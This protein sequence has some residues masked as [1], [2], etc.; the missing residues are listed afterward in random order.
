MVS[1]EGADLYTERRGG[2]PALL[3]IPGG[4]GDAGPFAPLADVLADT[5]TVLTYD[6]RGNS[7]SPLHGPPAPTTLAEQSADA[8]AVVRAHGFNEACFFGTSGGAII[9]LDLAAHHPGCM[10]LGVAHEPPVPK[11]LPDGQEILARYDEIDRVL[12]TEGWLKA[13]RMFTTGNPMSERDQPITQYVDPTEVDPIAALPPGPMRDTMVRMNG[14]WEF[15]TTYEIKSF[16]H[17][18]PDLDLIARNRVRLV[19]GGGS[20]TRSLFYHRSGRVIAERLGA[21]FVEFPGG[22]IGPFDKA[23]GF[24]QIIR[25]IWLTARQDESPR[26][27]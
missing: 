4:G 8:V 2:G 13:Y 25:S 14:N 20:E 15:M 12:R 3:L 6:R 5:F 1:A 9:V 18:V 17:Y 27:P 11:V 23:P 22:H 21:E 7:R 24:A 16:I 26:R 10:A 19:L